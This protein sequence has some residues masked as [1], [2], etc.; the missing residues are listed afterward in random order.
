MPKSVAPLLIAH[1]L[2]FSFDTVEVV[3]T[4]IVV[5]GVVELLLVGSQGIGHAQHDKPAMVHV[6]CS[7]CWGP[8]FES[9]IDSYVDAVS[10]ATI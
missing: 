7:V 4:E 8:A 6:I 9:S 5:V 3:V 1:R 2:L 10:V